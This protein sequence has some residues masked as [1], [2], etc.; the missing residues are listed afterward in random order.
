MDAAVDGNELTGTRPEHIAG[1]DAADPFAGRDLEPPL[2]AALTLAGVAMAW[3]AGAGRGAWTATATVGVLAGSAWLARRRSTHPP[4]FALRASRAGLALGAAAVAAGVGHGTSAPLLAWFPAVCAVYAVVFA[5]GAATAFTTA[6][7]GVLAV[8]AADPPS[9]GPSE[10]AF[11]ACAVAVV[12]VSL[13]G[14]TLRAVLADL[15]GGRP[16]HAG[17]SDVPAVPV[18]AAP[19]PALAV[20]RVAEPAVAVP[21]VLPDRDQL[22]QAVARAQSRAGVV[23]G[24]IGLL[25]LTLRGAGSLAASLGAAPAQEVLATLARRAR[26]WLPAGDVVAWLPD[27]RLAVLLEGVDAAACAMVARRL[28]A[29][30]AE[31]VT[32]AREV[33]SLPATAALALAEGPHESPAQLLHRAELAAPLGDG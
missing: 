20:P 8:L 13:A 17:A 21:A 19:V 24:E 7:L 26:A 22:L 11:A 28:A 18:P 15:A 29:L 30:L 10:T 3:A 16:Q 2:L 6:A 32:A 25:V 4:A 14:R 33:V 5:A 27:G 9:G 12:A 31:P 23:G 1:G